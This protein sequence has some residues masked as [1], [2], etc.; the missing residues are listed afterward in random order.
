MP[1]ALLLRLESVAII[2][3]WLDRRRVR[4]TCEQC[5]EDVN[6]QREIVR[7]GRTLCR[8]CAGDAYYVNRLEG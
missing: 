1:E 5:G 6:Y 3:G 2:P 4:V 8:A 7:R